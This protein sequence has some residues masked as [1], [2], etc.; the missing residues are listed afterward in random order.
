MEKIENKNKKGLV[1]TAILALFLI[2]FGITY[3]LFTVTLNG[4]KKVK[5]TTGT[6]KL[7]LLDANDNYIDNLNPNADTGFDIELSNAVPMS[8]EE[9]LEKTDNIYTFKL[10]NE[11]TINAKYYIK[12]EDLELD[13]G[14]E[15]LNDKYIE[16]EILRDGE[17]VGEYTK[18]NRT[19][20][21]IINLG[22]IK[23]NQVYTYT[24]RLWVTNTSS[25]DAMNKTFYAHLR[26]DSEQTNATKEVDLRVSN[27]LVDK[28]NGAVASYADT[29]DEGFDEYGEGLLKITNIFAKLPS[30]GD[31]FTYTITIENKGVLDL[32]VTTGYDYF[33]YHK[34][35]VA[36]INTKPECAAWDLD[37]NLTINA[38]DISTLYNYLDINLDKLT[39]KKI[40]SGGKETL[41]LFAKY[42]ENVENPI[43]LPDLFDGDLKIYYLK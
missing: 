39:N 27:I 32:D 16:Y 1:I 11:G 22:L 24:L 13:S 34:C 25:E 42:K 35:I 33:T 17:D 5:L 30:K 2:V 37:G 10:K 15:R 29:I 7:R 3:A 31:E 12:L 21:R 8:R 36:D 4:T 41:T 20:N 40:L 18:L 9:A 38:G 23:P 28:K 14:E 6:L 43:E 26:V 19:S